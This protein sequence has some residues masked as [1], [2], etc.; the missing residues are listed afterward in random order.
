MNV[1][2]AANEPNDKQEHCCVCTKQWHRK[3][4]TEEDEDEAIEY[5]TK[6]VCLY[7]QGEQ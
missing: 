5:D 2:T 1:V 3:R 7:V 6:C 4:K